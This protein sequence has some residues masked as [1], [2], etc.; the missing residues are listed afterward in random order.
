MKVSKPKKCVGLGHV[1][2]KSNSRKKVV[3]SSS[4]ERQQE[5]LWDQCEL[6]NR[7]GPGPWISGGMAGRLLMKVCFK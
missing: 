3:G 2:K 7:A 1:F 5:V 6:E 4:E